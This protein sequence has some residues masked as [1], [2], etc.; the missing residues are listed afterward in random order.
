MFTKKLAMNINAFEWLIWL[1]MSALTYCPKYLSK[2]KYYSIYYY[3]K[4]NAM[5]KTI[6]ILVEDIHKGSNATNS[7][8]MWH[9]RVK[10]HTAQM[11]TLNFVVLVQ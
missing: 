11:L 3:L 10:K 9:N 7:N 4:Y 1:V 6:I 2:S 5:Y 8:M